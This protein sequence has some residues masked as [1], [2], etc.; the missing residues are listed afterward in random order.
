MSGLKRVH[1]DK[2]PVFCVITPLKPGDK[3]SKDT[4]VTVKRNDY[5]FI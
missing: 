3:I 4:K 2:N 5:P 1:K